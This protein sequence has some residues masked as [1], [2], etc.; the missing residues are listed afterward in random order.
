MDD[1]EKY[2]T[3]NDMTENI[4]TILERCE[5]Y[6][7]WYNEITGECAELKEQLTTAQKEIERQDKVIRE[8]NKKKYDK[9]MEKD[10]IFHLKNRNEELETKLAASEERA[11]RYKSWHNEKAG[12][13]EDLKQQLAEKEKQIKKL[14]LEAQKYYEDAYCNDFHNQDKISFCIEQ[15]EKVVEFIKTRD[16]KGFF[17]EQCD[18]KEYI[19]NQI[20]VIKGDEVVC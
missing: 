11:E 15:L 8:V 16:N 1:N 3:I 7:R 2:A 14:N 18:I 9:L 13:C 10:I 20:K 12:E 4:D 5:R 17:P 6:K 19:D